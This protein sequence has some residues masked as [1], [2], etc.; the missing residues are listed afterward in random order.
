M[1]GGLSLS[2]TGWIFNKYAHHWATNV[3]SDLVW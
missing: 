1:D 2:S 3:A